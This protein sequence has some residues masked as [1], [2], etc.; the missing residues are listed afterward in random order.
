MA[1]LFVGSLPWATTNDDLAQL[2]SQAGTVITATVVRDRVTGR[3]KGYGF[4]EMAD[5]EAESATQM[6]N[7]T[8]YQGRTL[9][10]NPARP[11]EEGSHN[12]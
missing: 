1:K 2:F 4:V 12:A 8:D 5:A 10:V 11:K 9:V 6:L 7:G 3:S